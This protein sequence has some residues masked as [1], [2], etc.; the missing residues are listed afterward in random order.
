ML[1][2]PCRVRDPGA[3]SELAELGGGGGEFG[4]PSRVW[5]P[6][7]AWETLQGLG[8]REDLVRSGGVYRG[9]CCQHP[10]PTLGFRGSRF[11]AATL[12]QDPFSVP[13]PSHWPLGRVP[14]TLGQQD[15]AGTVPHAGAWL[16]VSCAPVQVSVGESSR[17]GV[18]PL[19]PS[20]DSD[21]GSRLCTPTGAESRRGLV[22]AMAPAPFA[23]H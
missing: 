15:A 20:P 14:E 23:S 19:P 12:G 2:G 5:E 10:Q 11:R 13:V 18:T 22:L 17:L 9:I 4:G 6:P 8:S 21:F 3:C 7:W 16:Q 1:E